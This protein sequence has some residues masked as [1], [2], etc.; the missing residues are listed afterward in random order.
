MKFLSRTGIL[1]CQC[2]HRALL[3]KLKYSVLLA[4]WS[5]LVAVFQLGRRLRLKS[6]LVLMLLARVTPLL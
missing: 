4:V 3:F 5:E 6:N 2:S 1:A